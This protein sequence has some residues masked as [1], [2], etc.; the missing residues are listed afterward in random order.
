MIPGIG[1]RCLNRLLYRIGVIM[2]K[3]KKARLGGA[4]RGMRP[5]RRARHG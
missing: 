3:L 2:L 1:I 5:V 4:M